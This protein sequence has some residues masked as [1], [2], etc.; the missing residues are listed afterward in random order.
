MAIPAWAVLQCDDGRGSA[1]GCVRLLPPSAAERRNFFGAR[2]LGMPESFSWSWREC[3]RTGDSKLST[4]ALCRLS[5]ISEWVGRT[6]PQTLA[7]I[8]SGLPVIQAQSA[9]LGALRS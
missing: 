4:L 6:N 1:V 8:T 3:G 9:V 2:L 7:R 5:A